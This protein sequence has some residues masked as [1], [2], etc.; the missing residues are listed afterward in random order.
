MPMESLFE[1][2]FEAG[3]VSQEYLDPN[4]RYGGY[5]ESRHCIFHQGAE[6]HIVQQC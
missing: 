6:G 2:L 5:D 4:I 1:C 3:Y